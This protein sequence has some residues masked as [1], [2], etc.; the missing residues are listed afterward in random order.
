MKRNNLIAFRK[1]VD[2][3]QKQVADALDISEVY[4]RKIENGNANPGRTTMLKFEVFFG[5]DSRELFPDLFE[6]HVDT[7]CIKK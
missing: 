5:I 1:K 2:L 3:T 4:V 6:V 7:K